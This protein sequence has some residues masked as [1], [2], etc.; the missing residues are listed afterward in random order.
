MLPTQVLHGALVV[1]MTLVALRDAWRLPV[2]NDHVEWYF[3]TIGKYF[4]G[5][6]DKTHIWQSSARCDLCYDGVTDSVRT[7]R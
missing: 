7:S 1:R 5:D 2:S 4:N 3:H 6:E